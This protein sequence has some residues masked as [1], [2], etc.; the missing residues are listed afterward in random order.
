[1]AP[2]TADA[3]PMLQFAA[4]PERSRAVWAGLPRL[5]WA[6]AGRAKPAATTLAWAPSAGAR[7]DEAAVIAAMPHGLGKGL[8]VRTDATRRARHGVGDAY[9]HRFWGQA[10]RWAAS[11]KL[12]AG[13]RLVR[14]GPARPRIAE[15]DRVALLARF[16]EDAPD[17][18]PGLLAAARIF[19]VPPG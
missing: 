13:N 4:E 15:G 1:A 7:D 10:V 5:P 6:L 8:R 12:A 2:A 14:F 17:I 3:W 9:H 11:G 19:R 18:G 16:A